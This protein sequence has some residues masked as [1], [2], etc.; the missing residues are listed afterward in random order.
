MQNFTKDH[1]MKSIFFDSRFCNQSIGIIWIESLAFSLLIGLY[2]QNILLGVGS[3]LF[4][5][6]LEGIPLISVMYTMLF[7][8]AESVLV[9]Y[10]VSERSEVK[11][12]F[13]A[14]L[15]AFYLLTALHKKAGRIDHIAFGYAMLLF[16]GILIAVTRFLTIREPDLHLIL[17]LAVLLLTM[18]PRLR[19]IL[20][21][22]LAAAAAGAVYLFVLPV[23]S[24]PYAYLATAFLFLYSGSAYLW[25]CLGNDFIGRWKQRKLL[26]TLEEKKQ[27]FPQIKSKIYE[28][29][30]VLAE[31]YRYYQTAVCANSEERRAFDLDWQHYV[32]YLDASGKNIT[33]NQF[34]DREK[35]Y[36]IRRYKDKPY[37]TNARYIRTG[38]ADASPKKSVASGYFAGVTDAASLK[39][40]YHEL[41]KIY[42]PD[43]QNGDTTVSR[44]I[45]KEYDS[46]TGKYN[47]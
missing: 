44:Q 34:F 47:S 36:Q 30:P 25:A 42:H 39:K 13:W 7:P 43:N 46:L 6:L 14:A 32:L 23:L 2:H 31:Q 17:L 45:Q 5:I 9:F 10:I 29:Y 37:R 16:D 21:I 3:C 4:L 33:F 28:K 8:L 18:V 15:A 35:L 38:Q 12:G 41:M 27:E 26:R 22:L 40:R 19:I 11:I 24:T 1:S 20:S